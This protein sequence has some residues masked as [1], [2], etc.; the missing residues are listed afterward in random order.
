MAVVLGG[1]E[2]RTR[3]RV[4][5]GFSGYTLL[6][7]YPETGRTHQIRVHLAYLGHPL[8]GD[9]AYGRPSPLLS[10]HFL[11]AFHLGFQHPTGGEP[12]DSAPN[13]PGK[14]RWWWTRSESERRT[15][16]AG[17]RIEANRCRS[18]WL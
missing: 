15:A 14:W 6:E 9:P 2:A 10:R 3:Y 4:V 11:H 5:E 12:V 7:L 17:H 18:P 16:E 1:R 8:L 13:C